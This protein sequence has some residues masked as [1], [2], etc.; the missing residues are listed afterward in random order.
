MT[1]GDLASWDGVG[2]GGLAGA[3]HEPLRQAGTGEVG[4]GEGEHTRCL[5]SLH[6][7]IWDPEIPGISKPLDAH[8]YV[9]FWW[10]VSVVVTSPPLLQLRAGMVAAGAERQTLKAF[11]LAQSSSAQG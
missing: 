10:E 8:N 4:A 6:W 3:L 9:C 7:N 11:Q 2:S 5:S 1:N